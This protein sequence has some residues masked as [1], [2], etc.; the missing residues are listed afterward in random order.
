M[1]AATAA[2]YQ[3]PNPQW[4]Y[5]VF[6]RVDKDGSGQI[7]ASEL[8]GALSNGTWRPFNPVNKVNF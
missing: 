4:L 8:Q 7:N 2:R 3:M 1:A 5:D 6:R